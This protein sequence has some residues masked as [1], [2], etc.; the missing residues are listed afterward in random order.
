MIDALFDD[1]RSGVDG[2]A[3]AIERLDVAVYGLDRTGLALSVLCAQAV[4]SVT[5]ADADG[6]RV[7][8][9]RRGQPPAGGPLVASALP[10]EIEAGRLRSTTDIAA[11]AAD[12]RIHLLAVGAGLRTD[13]TPDC[14]ALRST[15]RDAA[16]GV[17]PGDIVVVIPPVPPGTTEGVVARTLAD[18]G[19]STEAVG[20]GVWAL[21]T[22][23]SLRAIRSGD[24]VVAGTDDR[25]RE[26][27]AD[28][29]GA[30][31]AG[32]VST[33]PTVATA[34]CVDAVERTAEEMLR[35]LSNEL[36]V[37]AGIDAATVAELVSMRVDRPLPGPGVGGSQPIGAGFLRDAVADRTPLTD[38]VYRS[39]REFP[40]LIAETVL[41]AVDHDPEDG[42]TTV[43][44]VG[45]PEAGADDAAAMPLSLLVR[46][47]TRAETRPL[48]CD[49]VADLPRG[50]TPH[51]VSIRAANRLNPDAVVVLADRL[52]F[53]EL[54]WERYDAPVVDCCGSAL[55]VGEDRQRLGRPDSLRS[56]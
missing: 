34:E 39:T 49:P 7:S 6:S 36:A 42:E 12:A 22:D 19:P 52:V 8:A 48:V 17:D 10:D 44:I 11:A 18:G 4:G 37:S 33:V 2:D 40:R 16:A 9:V 13:D 3:L 45:V 23:R 25:S 47:L 51:A 54:D 38:S 27:V 35:S 41:D 1:R 32:T 50:L 29:A 43:L 53:E 20:L 46:A 56:R 21:P 14:S 30:T 24:S 15:L 55:D 5:A 31:T 28:L 26:A